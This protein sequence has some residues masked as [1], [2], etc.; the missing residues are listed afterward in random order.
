MVNGEVQL[1]ALVNGKKIVVIEASVRRNPQL[2]DANGVDCLP[3]ATI[4]EQLTLIG[5]A[6]AHSICYVGIMKKK[7]MLCWYYEEIVENTYALFKQVTQRCL[8]L[9]THPTPSEEDAFSSNFP[10]YL[11]PASP[12]YIPT[13]PRKTYSSSSNSF[14]IVPLTSP[15]LSLFHDDPYMK[16]LQAFYTKKSPIPPPTI[17]PPSSI[18]KPQEFFPPK[19]FLSPKKRGQ[20]SSSTSS[21]PQAFEVGESSRKTSIERHKEQIEEIRNYLGELSLDRIVHIEDKVEVVVSVDDEEVVVTGGGGDERGND[22]DDGMEIM[23]V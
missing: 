22:G 3:N 15:T 5:C 11:P 6:Y 21:L 23:N 14:G 1:Q 4:F 9:P 8:S 19:E 12:D 10:N 16:V 7:V 2:E 20:S 18:P 13:S 17:I